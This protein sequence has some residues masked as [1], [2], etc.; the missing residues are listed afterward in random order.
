VLERI[1]RLFEIVGDIHQVGVNDI[2][3]QVLPERVAQLVVIFG[4]QCL[5]GS[6]LR[7][8]PRFWASGAG[9]EK[10]TL[11]GDEC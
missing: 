10:F 3:A 4:E 2:A 5:E 11:L 6:Q 7:L 9:E 8:A 1:V